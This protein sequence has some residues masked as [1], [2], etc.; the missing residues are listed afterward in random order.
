MRHQGCVP[1]PPI[2]PRVPVLTQ[3]SLPSSDPA[4]QLCHCSAACSSIC[5]ILGHPCCPF[6]T[7]LPAEVAWRHTLATALP[8]PAGYIRP[9]GDTG[10]CRMPWGRG[11]TQTC[12]SLQ[13]PRGCRLPHRP[14]LRPWG[15]QQPLFI[16]PPRSRSCWLIGTWQFPMD[17]DWRSTKG[18]LS[19]GLQALIKQGWG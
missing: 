5:T 17:R 1:P 4:A 10:G 14:V 8:S 12:C 11:T 2:A 16:S 18:H 19:A 9:S 7:A 3:S 13:H 15:G 6:H